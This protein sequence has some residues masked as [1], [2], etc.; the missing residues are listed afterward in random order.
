MPTLTSLTVNIPAP[1]HARPFRSKALFCLL[2][3]GDRFWQVDSDGR[4]MR[5]SLDQI[6]ED[7]TASALTLLMRILL[8]GKELPLCE[9]TVCP[10]AGSMG[11][12]R[13]LQPRAPW[14]SWTDGP[15]GACSWR[16]TSWLQ[17]R[18]RLWAGISP[19]RCSQIPDPWTHG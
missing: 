17:A 15:S 8:G 6:T 11:K 3:L 1:S 4:E 12:K 10:M 13:G 18:E 5:G 7:D 19:P 16:P 9:D 14:V 2:H